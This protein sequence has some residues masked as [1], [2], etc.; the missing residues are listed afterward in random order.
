[1]FGFLYIV[2]LHQDFALLAG[3]AF[4]FSALALVMYL[5]RKLD[6]SRSLESGG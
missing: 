1:M 3:S 4:V 6:W 5:T 2:L